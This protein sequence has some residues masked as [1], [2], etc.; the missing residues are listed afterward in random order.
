MAANYEYYI[1]YGGGYFYRFI[2]Q[3]PEFNTPEF[4]DFVES[5]NKA[6]RDDG[7]LHDIAK[8]EVL[9]LAYEYTELHWRFPNCYGEPTE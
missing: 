6:D 9:R 2:K 8:H 7:E 4:R 3:N 1:K 5:R